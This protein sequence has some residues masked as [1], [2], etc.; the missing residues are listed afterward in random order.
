LLCGEF[1]S[2]DPVPDEI[3][4]K[5]YADPKIINA[6]FVR[7]IIPYYYLMDILL[8][9]S[10]REGLASVILEAN[11]ASKPVI[12]TKVTGCLD[13]VIDG[14]TGLLVPVRDSNELAKK[15]EFLMTNPLI[16]EKMGKEGRKRVEKDFR[17][18]DIWGGYLELYKS[19]I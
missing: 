11:A 9:P 1:E 8:L 18:R 3:K 6:G 19:L 7:D 4:R 14:V 2:G 15:I 16:A 13:A 17:P 12:A 10:Y 5:I